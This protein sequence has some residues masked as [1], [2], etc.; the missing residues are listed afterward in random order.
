MRRF[1]HIITAL[2]ICGIISVPT[3]EAQGRHG[4]TS[5]GNNNRI[6]STG[7]VKPATRHDVSGS[8]N[9]RKNVGG[10]RLDG[11]RPSVGTNNNNQGSRPN[12]GNNNSGVGNNN[13]GGRPGVSNP[14]HNNNNPGFGNNNHGGRPGVGNPG[15][16]N[17]TPGFGNNNN[18]GR[19]G[20]GGAHGNPGNG[21]RP[22]VPRP[23][24]MVP[25]P[26]PYRPPIF[27]PSVRPLPPP[28]WRPRPGLPVIRGILGLT[29]GTALQLSIDYLLNAGYYIDGYANDVVYLRDVNALN[30]M[31]PDGAL[32]YG[33]AGLDGSAF[34]YSTAGYDLTRYNNVYRTLCSQFG[35]PVNVNNNSGIMSATW[36]GGNNGYITLS[37]GTSTMTGGLRYLTTLSFG[38]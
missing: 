23:P 35:M 34:Y 7:T 30:Y 4:R 38:L 32:Y 27:R 31:W 5:G 2:F 19:P 33:N 15:H 22:G 24:H 36:F 16:N 12:N 8:N 25:P 29:F 11:S 3:V 21:L 9:N 14:G 28:G 10:T 26:R 20:V 17:N 1:L 6:Q 37:Y 18:G 13:H